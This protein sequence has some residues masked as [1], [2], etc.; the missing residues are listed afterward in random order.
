MS[1]WLLLVV[2][3]AFACKSD[4]NVIDVADGETDDPDAYSEFDGANLRI[5]RPLSASFLPLEEPHPF[6]AALTDAAGAPLAFEEVVWSSSVDAD[7]AMTGLAFEDT[8]LGVGVHDIT[9]EV[10]LPNGDRLAH[11]VG[12]VRLQ[13]IYAGTYAGLFSADIEFEYDGT[14]YTVTC[15]G[16]AILVVDAYG[17]KATG[18]AQCLL[19]LMGYDIDAT[20]TFDMDNDEGELTGTASADLMFTTYDF[21]AT[22]ELDPDDKTLHI[23]FGGDVMG[24]GSID[25]NVD[26]SQISLETEAP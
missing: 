11:T 21:E 19:S 2:P 26:T 8:T 12:G 15:S 9:A 25:A 4:S 14:P 18:D 13:S 22:G 1:R 3:L 17:E 20:Y 7:W 24:Q 6:E 10:E 5:V 23:A 16:A